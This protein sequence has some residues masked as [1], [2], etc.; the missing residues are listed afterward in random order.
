MEI[1]AKQKVY[2]DEGR[3][4]APP[5]SRGY[6]NLVQNTSRQASRQSWGCGNWSKT[7][8]NISQRRGPFFALKRQEKAD[9]QT[10][11][12][13]LIK[14]KLQNQGPKTGSFAV[15]HGRT[16]KVAS[17]LL[18]FSDMKLYFN[19][20]CKEN[21]SGVWPCL[22]WKCKNVFCLN[23]FPGLSFPLLW[24][25]LLVCCAQLNKIAR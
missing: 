15:T 12:Q 16:F 1:A 4:S 21:M 14:M 10:W 11:A 18:I 13:Y 5:G 23:N 22:V 8:Y 7:I 25:K 3:L 19:I 24:L 2:K 17:M 9:A 6:G 20:F